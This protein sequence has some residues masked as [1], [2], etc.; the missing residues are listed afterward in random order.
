M[1]SE[2]FNQGLT[3]DPEEVRA[4]CGLYG[5]WGIVNDNGTILHHIASDPE[6]FI[7]VDK[8]VRAAIKNGVDVNHRSRD[9]MTALNLFVLA[10][11]EVDR[12]DLYRATELIIDFGADVMI[13]GN[14]GF[15]PIHNAMYGSDKQTVVEALLKSASHSD[16]ILS[17]KIDDECAIH[18]AA[19]HNFVGAINALLEHGDDI[20][21][22]TT[23][24]A[25]PLMLASMFGDV[26]F[27]DELIRCGADIFAE[28]VNGMNAV[29]Y[30]KS[31]D[32]IHVGSYLEKLILGGSIKS[33]KNPGDSLCL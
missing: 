7:G 19:R 9:G 32:N 6:S 17:R 24:G 22:T 3:Y 15:F 26:C 18:I 1:F 14:D 28:D 21:R 8:V 16:E 27:I 4:I 10:C 25:T 30:A 5:L 29:S 11:G 33:K 23:G 31:N 13:P 2:H 12:I 20:N